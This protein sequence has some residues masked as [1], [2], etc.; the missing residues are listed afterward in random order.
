MLSALVRR[1]PPGTDGM[2]DQEAACRR[3]NALR[4][5]THLPA[6]KVCGQDPQAILLGKMDDGG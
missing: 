5:G 4:E 6:G 3:G 1:D 2:S